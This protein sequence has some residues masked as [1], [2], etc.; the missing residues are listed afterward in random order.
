MKN[1]LL[2]PVL[3]LLLFSCGGDDGGTV[4]PPKNKLPPAVNLSNPINNLLCID[5]NL[6]FNWEASID[7]DD[8]SVTYLLELA[9]DNQFAQITH[10]FDNLTVPN[11]TI[12]LDKGIAYYWRVKAIDDKGGASAYSSVFQFY[13]EGVGEIN[14]LPF[15]PS[16]INPE[17]ESTILGTSSLLSW[18]CSD[19]DVDDVLTYDVYLG[20]NNPPITTVS[21]DQSEKEYSATLMASTTYFW[22]VVVKDDKGGVTIG[23]VWS[24]K[25]N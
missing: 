13:T 21:I 24:F 17:I 9:T 7:H 2:V 14:H 11:K 25:T 8:D 1:F 12:L 4:E 23:Q 18:G 16:L 6:T 15:L 20:T 3:S 10:S 22:K 19:V 5:H